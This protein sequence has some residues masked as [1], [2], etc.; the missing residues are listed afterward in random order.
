MPILFPIITPQ[1]LIHLREDANLVIADVSTGTQA[2]ETYEKKH[3]DGALFFDLNTQLADIKTNLADGGRHP[4]PTPD[5]FG[6]MLGSLG[7]TPQSHVIIYDGQQGANAGARLW[8]MLEAAGHKKVQVLDGGLGAAEKAGYP[9]NGNMVTVKGRGKYPLDHWQLPIVDME[10]VERICRDENFTIIDVRD[11]E[12]YLGNTEPI[13]LIAGHIPGAINIP[14]TENLDPEGRFLS[15][16]ILK[17]KYEKILNAKNAGHVIVHCGSGVTAC[18][19]LLA[20]HHAGLPIPSLYVGSWSE[21][22]RNNKEIATG[23]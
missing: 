1:E 15:A 13:D 6:N 3:L 18:H 5:A 7:I 17:E 4:L 9:V 23:G 11:H 12:R 2:R 8:W 16:G 21:W 22:S 20:M 19:S 14:Y 10:T